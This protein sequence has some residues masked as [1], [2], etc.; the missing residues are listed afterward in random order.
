MVEIER[1]DAKW[2]LALLKNYDD[3]GPRSEGWQLDSLMG[4]LARLETAIEKA[5][6]E[7]EADFKYNGD[8]D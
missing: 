6:A 4:M 5:E 2:I 7:E 3:A 1:D 8:W